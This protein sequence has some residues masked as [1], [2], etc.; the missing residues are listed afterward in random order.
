LDRLDAALVALRLIHAAAVEVADQLLDAGGRPVPPRRDLVED[1]LEP[2]L[3]RLTGLPAPAPSRHR[4][5][6]RILR[7]PRTVGERKQIAAGL[8][9]AIESG[10]IDAVLRGGRAGLWRH[11][12][13]P[14]PR[15]QRDER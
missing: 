8:G 5:R 4:C 9:R 1:V 6:D 11:G 15:E 13:R 12:A 7:A 3:G 2:L 14:A 10:G